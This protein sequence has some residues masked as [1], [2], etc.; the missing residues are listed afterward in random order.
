M[1][2]YAFG[3]D[4]DAL[5]PAVLA[6]LAPYL[7]SQFS[8]GDLVAVGTR[9]GHPVDA[10]VWPLATLAEVGGAAQFGEYWQR[11]PAQALHLVAVTAD[12]RSGAAVIGQVMAAL[13]AAQPGLVDAYRCLVT[14]AGRWAYAHDLLD[15]HERLRPVAF[16][17][18]EA[19]AVVEALA[20]RAAV[21]RF[22]EL[23]RLR[24]LGPESM[25]RTRCRAE[26]IRRDRDA[27]GDPHERTAADVQLYLACAAAEERSEGEVIAVG[28]A[29]AANAELRSWLV[30]RLLHIA[31]GDSRLW[32]EVAA[33]CEG[34]ER[35]VACALAALAAW[36]GGEDFAM[37]AA[38]AALEAD[39]ECALAWTVWGLLETGIAAASIN[40]LGL[41]AASPPHAGGPVAPRQRA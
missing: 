19:T 21:R 13:T 37:A 5:D 41:R 34:T 6:G 31:D 39:D 18:D 25:R 20:V 40:A 30:D 10:V 24:P 33:H 11:S 16:G 38:E 3:T 14:T 17:G 36:T 2:S 28:I 1:R 26:Q 23:G 7:R 15:G 35:A 8:D 12:R 4:F 27:V 32:C 9:D 29:A 22:G